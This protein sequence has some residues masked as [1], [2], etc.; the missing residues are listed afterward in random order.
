M[1]TTDRT[2]YE[3]AATEAALAAGNLL[4]KRFRT[5]MNVAH[6]GVIDLVTEV[7]LAAEA[8][9]VSALQSEFPG[10]AILAEEGHAGTARGRVAWII[11]PLDGTT[12]Y[13]HGLPFFSVSIGLEI[14]GEI[15][16]GVVHVPVLGEVFTAHRGLGARLN[17]V[18]IHVSGT[19]SLS[20]SLLTTGFPYDIRTS[21]ETNLEF[22]AEFSRRSF[23]V[24][25][26]GSAA[27]DFCYVAAGRYDGFWELKLN[28]WDCAAGYLMVR[29]AGGRVT[30]FRGRPGSIYDRESLATNG[31]IHDEMLNILCRPGTTAAGP[32]GLRPGIHP[33]TS[34][35]AR[36]RGGHHE[37]Q[38]QD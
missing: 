31:L 33:A 11:D 16:F 19:S 20:A 36:G 35:E 24:R 5:K 38:G 29:E 21:S 8:L 6:K 27:M 7:D 9:I 3:K 18:P 15:E 22:F 12:N 26:A 13:A 10:C 14:E 1:G 25:R 23:A 37:D 4:I 30:N 17:G 2:R 32:N 34:P 28:P